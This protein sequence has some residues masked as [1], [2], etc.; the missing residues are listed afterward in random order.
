M[1]LIYDMDFTL[2]NDNSDGGFPVLSDAV[3]HTLQYLPSDDFAYII[4]EK[5]Y[6]EEEE[7]C[8]VFQGKVWYPRDT[9]L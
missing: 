7:I 5:R 4:S 9:K 6:G 8:I 2:E 1:Y 3:A